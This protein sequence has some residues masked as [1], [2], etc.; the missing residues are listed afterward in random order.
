[1]PMAAPAQIVPEPVTVAVGSPPEIAIPLLAC[2][3]A[4]P[5]A[6]VSVTI[7]TTVPDDPAVNVMLAPVEAEVIVPLQPA[8]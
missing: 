1:M 6:L 2:A 7:S 8:T 5:D 4:Q 3:D